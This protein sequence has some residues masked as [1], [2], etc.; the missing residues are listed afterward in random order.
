MSSLSSRLVCRLT[1]AG[2]IVRG[3]ERPGVGTHATRGPARGRWDDR[4]RLHAA[5]TKMLRGEIPLTSTI[6]IAP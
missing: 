1:M 6:P 2:A 5:G 3:L 4:Y